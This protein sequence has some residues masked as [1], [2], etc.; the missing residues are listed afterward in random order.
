MSHLM[1]GVQGGLSMFGALVGGPA[2]EPELNGG[3]H[4][5]GE[6]AGLVRVTGGWQRSP[7]LGRGGE[8]G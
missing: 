8:G 5:G 2:R 1:L 7:R 3:H 4:W 6:E